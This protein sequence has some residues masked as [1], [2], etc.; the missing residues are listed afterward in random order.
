MVM[1]DD[2]ANNGQV[3]PNAMEQPEQND[4][5]QFQQKGH[6]LPQQEDLRV[7][8]HDEFRQPFAP[9]DPTSP[10]C[11]G[12]HVAPWPV[13]YRPLVFK[14]FNGMTDSRQFIMSYEAA[15][16]SAGGNNDVM[17]KSLVIACEGP[18]LGW[19]SKLQP[20]SIFSW[21]HLKSK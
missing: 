13:T 15:I 8:Q 16:A 9:Y 7:P 5:R 19:F 17:A 10:L 1:Q 12:L 18:A 3:D 14:K 20:N 2:S 4:P 21:E 6:R 11:Q